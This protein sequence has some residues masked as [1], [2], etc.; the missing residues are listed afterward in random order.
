MECHFLTASELTN[1]INQGYVQLGGPYDTEAECLG[2]CG[3]SSSSS[4][5]SGSSEWGCVESIPLEL[6]VESGPYTLERIGAEAPPEQWFD[7]PNPMGSYAVYINASANTGTATSVILTTYSGDCGDQTQQ[8][9]GYVSG[10]GSFCFSSSTMTGPCYAMLTT[11]F[12]LCT[13]TITI[14]SGACPP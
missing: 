13:Y 8:I 3:S 9:N 10:T 7:F 4:S 12:G 14:E 5:S 2:N 6:G 11:D 1:L